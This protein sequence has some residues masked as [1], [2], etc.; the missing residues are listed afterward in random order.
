MMGAPV[1]TRDTGFL[2]Y[3]CKTEPSLASDPEQ[4]QVKG[5]GSKRTVLSVA[6]CA[7]GSGNEEWRQLRRKHSPKK[8]SAKRGRAERPH[9]SSPPRLLLL[10]CGVQFL[11]E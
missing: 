7:M 2:P 8:Q 4:R 11:S 3:C 9:L 5:N 1:W 6:Q 10:L